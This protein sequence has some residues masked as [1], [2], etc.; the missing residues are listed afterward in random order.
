MGNFCPNCGRELAEGEVCNCTSANATAET[1]VNAAQET[2][3]NAAGSAANTANSSAG[4]LYEQAMNQ[5]Q[6]YNQANAGNSSGAS[7][8]SSP[9]TATLALIWPSF[10][11]VWKSPVEVGRDYVKGA[12]K[13]LSFFFYII[14]ALCAA[15]FAL[16][17]VGKVY[18]SINQSFNDSMYGYFYDEDILTIPYARTFFSVLIVAVI[19]SFIFAGLVCLCNK[20]YG[21]S[22]SFKEAMNLV[23]V[24]SIVVAPIFLLALVVTLILPTVGYFIFAVANIKAVL[25]MMEILPN[26]CAATRDKMVKIMFTTLIVVII[27]AS[28][29]SIIIVPFVL[30]NEFY[31]SINEFSGM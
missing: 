17:A 11:K 14:E 18:K 7:M 29:V 1:V 28:I 20:L 22:M 4:N 10:L 2:S 15:F 19:I 5:Q 13:L 30:P 27:V 9:V 3:E 23:A 16:V 26:Y 25:V 21:N 8:A 12:D 31:S 24:R 6:S